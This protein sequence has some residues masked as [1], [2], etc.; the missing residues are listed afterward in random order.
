MF[1]YFEYV[2]NGLLSRLQLE[3][4]D[5]IRNLHWQKTTGWTEQPF[6]L[7]S[8]LHSVSVNSSLS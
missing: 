1:Y 2:W 8:Y 7:K 4:N 5:D 3:S 6:H